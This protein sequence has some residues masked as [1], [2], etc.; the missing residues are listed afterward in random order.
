MQQKEGQAF[1]SYKARAQHVTTAPVPI[2]SEQVMQAWQDLRRLEEIQ[3]QLLEVEARLRE[4]EAAQKQQ[5]ATSGTQQ[6][7]RPGAR[8]TKKPRSKN[9]RSSKETLHASSSEMPQTPGP[10]APPLSPPVSNLDDDEPD[11]L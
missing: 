11:R 7:P 4:A 2:T 6:M 3:R 8:K 10:T 5:A 1:W 9:A